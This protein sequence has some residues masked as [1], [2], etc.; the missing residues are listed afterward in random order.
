MMTMKRMI[1]A[2]GAAVFMITMMLGGSAMAADNNA[3]WQWIS[4]DNKYSK[5]MAPSKVKIMRAYGNVAV[6]IVAWTKTTYGVD[7]ARETLENYGLK[8]ITPEQLSYSLAEVEINPQNRTIAYQNEAFYDKNGKKLWEKVYTPIKPKEINS[9]EFDEDFYCSIVDVVFNQ[10]EVQRRKATD[11]WLVLWQS[12]PQE[13]GYIHSMADTTTMRL[14]GENIIYWEWQ[15]TKAPN[16]AVK[17]I[18]FQKKAVNIPQYTEKIIRLNRWTPEN[19]WE[20]L[21]NKTDGMYH[22]IKKGT[23]SEQTLKTLRIYEGDNEAWM[24]RYSLDN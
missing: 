17:E 19:G 9:Q 15:E 12:S 14:K 8:N 24:R 11:R 3:D 7:G 4:T 16:G 13:G 21:T 22:P 5:Y 23:N 2:I 10:G 1:S 18:A 20:D 6:Q